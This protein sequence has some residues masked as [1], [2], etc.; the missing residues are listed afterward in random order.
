MVAYN[1]NSYL[2]CKFG[3]RQAGRKERDK[4]TLD[5]HASAV[6]IF[7]QFERSP[8]REGTFQ[9]YFLKS[10]VI[11]FQENRVTALS[12]CNNSACV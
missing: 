8:E 7:G 2:C 1:K 12:K 11:G 9:E 3:G 10:R 4:K 5:C 6:F